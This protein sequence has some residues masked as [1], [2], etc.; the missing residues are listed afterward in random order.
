[1]MSPLDIRNNIEQTKEN[2]RDA[3]ISQ[4]IVDAIAQAY[5]LCGKAQAKI[6]KLYEEIKNATF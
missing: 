2:K 5:L 6:D 3:Y 4:L 1:M